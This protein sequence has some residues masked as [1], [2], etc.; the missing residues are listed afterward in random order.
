MASFGMA[1]Q[2]QLTVSTPTNVRASTRSVACTARGR[3]GFAGREIDH[4]VAERHLV[5]VRA[6]VARIARET[7]FPL[8]A[9][10]RLSESAASAHEERIEHEREA[11]AA[12][13]PA[14][15]DDVEVQVR[16]LRSTGVANGRP[17]ARR[18]SHAD[19]RPPPARCPAGGGRRRHRSVSS[20]ITTWLPSISLSSIWLWSGMIDGTWSG[21]PSWVAITSPSPTA[22]TGRHSQPSS[23]DPGN[24]PARGTPHH[25]PG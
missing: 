20:A 1:S 3:G 17:V 11:M 15:A 10:S 19:Q 18:P 16:R 2:G 24:H 25:P 8:V 5:L 22:N 7:G 4:D 6:R 12:A 14:F 13:R 9:A 21:S 23:A